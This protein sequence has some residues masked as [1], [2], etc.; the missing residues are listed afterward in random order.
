MNLLL[1]QG[2]GAMEFQVLDAQSFGLYIDV[3]FNAVLAPLSGPAL[4]PSSYV[5]TGPSVVQVGF[6]EVLPAGHTIRLHVPDQLSAQPYILTLPQQGILDANG[7]ALTSFIVNFS[8]QSVPTTL[9][10]VKS[11][12]ERTI[13]IVFSEAVL[14]ED[15]SN[16][17][18]YSISPALAVT[19]ATR[20][21]D[22]NYRLTTA[23]QTIGV[24]YDVTISGIR[25]IQGNI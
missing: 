1:T 10:I 4:L 16:P 9:Q 20:I 3:E 6:L 19:K 22:F 24:T 2:L 18:N 23:P 5:I 13:D 8:G 7:N 11:V 17:A 25:D 15:A 21:T 14:E 12:D